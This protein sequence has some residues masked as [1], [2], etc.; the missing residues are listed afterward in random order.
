MLYFVTVPQFHVFVLHLFIFFQSIFFLRFRS[1][2][3]CHSVLS[4]LNLFPFSLHFVVQ[5]VEF[6]ILG[7]VVFSYKV[8]IWYTFMSS[9]SVLRLFFFICFTVFVVNH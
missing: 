2:N 9:I 8:P 6:L 4:L 3:F 7:I 5:T 1:E